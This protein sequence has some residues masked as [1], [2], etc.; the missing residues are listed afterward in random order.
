MAS[1]LNFLYKA[2]VYEIWRVSLD[3]VA[4]HI[5]FLQLVKV[6]LN[7]AVNDFARVKMRAE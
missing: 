6:E 4:R 5:R 7:A 3:D 1:L 2:P